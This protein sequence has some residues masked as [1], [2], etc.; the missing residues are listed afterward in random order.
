MIVTDQ[1]W[2]PAF[3]E[4]LDRY[5]PGFK[6]VEGRVIT[7]A[8]VDAEPDAP[9]QEEDVL[10]V[11]ALSRWTAN[12][13]EVTVATNGA[14]KPKATRKLIWTV[15][16]YVFNVANCSRLYAFCSVD[17]DKS[18]AVQE[19]LCLTREARLADHY[20]EGKDAFLYGITKA[21]WLNSRWA[22]P[23]Q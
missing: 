1:H 13:C 21:Q 4:W 10:T 5:C 8:Y 14:K 17:N 22:T 2:Q 3:V 18:I 9:A 12:T 16:D 6:N 15:F 19:N 7:F 20:G 23:D 11:I